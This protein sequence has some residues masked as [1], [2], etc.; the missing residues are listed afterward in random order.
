MEDIIKRALTRRRKK[1]GRTVAEEPNERLVHVVKFSI[2]MTACLAAIE[3][4]HLAVLRTWNSEVF[5][6]ITGLIGTVTGIFV[7]KKS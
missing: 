4:A 7:G 2:G 6:A 1:R 3:I 5:A